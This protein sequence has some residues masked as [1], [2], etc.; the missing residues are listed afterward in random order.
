MRE[1]AVGV[2][3][4]QVHDPDGLKLYVAEAVEVRL[5]VCV[6]D[7]AELR[8]GDGEGV[9]VVVGLRLTVG[10]PLAVRVV[11]CVGAEGVGVVLGVPDDEVV[12]WCVVETDEV[13]LSVGEGDAERARVAVAVDRVAVLVGDLLLTELGVTVGDPD[14]EGVRDWLL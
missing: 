6:R 11:V 13:G 2:A 9:E 1:V 8:V 14:A 12:P 5:T 4:A 7:N 3:E 10:V